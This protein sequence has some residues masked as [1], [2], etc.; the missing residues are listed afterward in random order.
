MNYDCD[1]IRNSLNAKID[2]LGREFPDHF[3]L[4]F[5]ED[6]YNLGLDVGV[7]QENG[8]VKLW[9]FEVNVRDVGIDSL[10][11]PDMALTHSLY[12]SYLAESHVRDCS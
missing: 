2:K 1:D 9:L 5:N 3:C 12:M 11:A 8:Q 4:F 7:T 6:F 10:L